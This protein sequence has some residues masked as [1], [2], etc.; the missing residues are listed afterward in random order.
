MPIGTFLL[1]FAG[2]VE[3]TSRLIKIYYPIQELSLIVLI[4]E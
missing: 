4:T 1:R 3:L 2:V